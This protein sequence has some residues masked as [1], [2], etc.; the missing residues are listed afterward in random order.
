MERDLLTRVFT[1]VVSPEYEQHQQDFLRFVAYMNQKAAAIGM[2][3]SQFLDAA[4]M[5]NLSTARDLL[6]LLIYADARIEQRNR[7]ST[8]PL[9]RRKA[10]IAWIG[11]KNNSRFCILCKTGIFIG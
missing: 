2:T 1:P 8:C 11:I 7:P 3:K 9:C 6:R 5:H 10:V 4:G